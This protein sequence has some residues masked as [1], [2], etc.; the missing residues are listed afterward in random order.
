[1]N[2]L[3]KR[4]C[5]N[6]I[7]FK[8]CGGCSLCEASICSKNC[9][10]CGTLCPRRGSSIRYLNEILKAPEE[11]MTNKKAG[12]PHHIPIL[13]DRL[14]ETLDPE[15]AKMI[16]VHGGN[17]FS[18]NGESVRKVYREKGFKKVLNIDERCGGILEF[19]VK[20]RTLEGIW[21]NR[22]SIY[23]ELLNQNFD[24]IIAPNFSVYE[25]CPRI[26]HIYNIQRS[27]I[28][29]NEL[30]KLGVNAVPDI[31][32]YNIN[33][34]D[35]WVYR[36]NKSKC[37]IIA[38]SFQVVD[39]RLKASN[40]W[41]DYLAGFKYL[42]KGI[43][44]EISII[45]VGITSHDRI[46]ELMS[47]ASSNI[48]IHILNQSAYLQSQR[49]MNSDGR[50]RDI[51]TPKQILFYKNIKYFNNLCEKVSRESVNICLKEEHQV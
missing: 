31:S 22:K 13:P 38:F 37:K 15:M 42:C 7:F 25:D 1:M 40:A 30:I 29:Y 44:N 3:C 33:D 11:L 6:C 14:S 50:V 18:K 46:V 21:D 36:I 48:S 41:K 35:N 12:I 2:G 47:V 8:R 10:K 23:P 51:H 4:K 34:L 28:V 32:W 9:L 5:S 17:V 24:L 16:G 27:I 20:D 49:G 39:L 19:Y 26:E 43:S 45:V